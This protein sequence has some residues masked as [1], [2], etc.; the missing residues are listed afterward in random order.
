[1]MSN[2]ARLVYMANQIATNLRT[3]GSE[4]A[5]LA[6]ADH[7]ARFWDPRMRS[8]ILE[9]QAQHSMELDPVADAAITILRDKGA[10]PPQT[11]ATKFNHVD[12]VGRSDAG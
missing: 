12:E 7:I 4:K 1:M 6:V 5:A 10:P 3:L 11:R 8:Q 2:Q 9:I